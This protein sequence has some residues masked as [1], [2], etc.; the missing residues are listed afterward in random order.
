MSRQTDNTTAPVF[1]KDSSRE[2]NVKLKAFELTLKIKAVTIST[3][4]YNINKFYIFYTHPV[5]IFLHNY[6]NKQLLF[7]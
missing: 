2:I 4:Y 7:R 1:T 5:F 3:A 6:Q